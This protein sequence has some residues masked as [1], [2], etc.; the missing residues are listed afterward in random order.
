[1][2]DAED[3]DFYEMDIASGSIMRG[4]MAE[5]VRYVLHGAEEDKP[6]S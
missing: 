3:K 2:T 1:M 5:K 6:F 4:F